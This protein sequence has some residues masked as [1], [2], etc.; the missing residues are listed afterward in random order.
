M[1]PL[2]SVVG[3]IIC[4]IFLRQ[5]E[6]DSEILP[7]SSEGYHR[8]FFPEET[9][10]HCVEMQS[11]LPHRYHVFRNPHTPRPSCASS[12]NRIACLIM[13]FFSS[14]LHFHTIRACPEKQRSHTCKSVRNLKQCFIGD[15]FFSLPRD[16]FSRAPVIQ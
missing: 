8:S 9:N 7:R 14:L 1:L 15:P 3:S 10:T 6:P 2:R 16:W 4:P 13:L 12:A 5:N 11:P